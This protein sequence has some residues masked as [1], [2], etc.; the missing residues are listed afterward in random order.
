MVRFEDM[1]FMP[2]MIV[3]QMAACAGVDLSPTFHFQ[4]GSSKGHGSHTSFVNAITKTGDAVRRS[5]G[6]T[7]DD[8]AYAAKHLDPELMRTFSYTM[9]SLSSEK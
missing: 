4:T 6:L 2:G 3:K 7:D 9:P 8:M 1:L 5:A